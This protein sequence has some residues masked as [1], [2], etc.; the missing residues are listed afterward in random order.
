MPGAISSGTSA[1]GGGQTV[2]APA[3]TGCGVTKKKSNRRRK[4]SGALG[5]RKGSSFERKICKLLSLWWSKG[6]RDD[7]LW[8][9]AASGARHTLL[10]R[11]GKSIQQM[12]DVVAVTA[13]GESFTQLFYV[14]CKHMKQLTY[15]S[16]ML[17]RNGA[18]YRFLDSTWDRAL[19]ENREPLLIGRGNNMPIACITSKAGIETI[20]ILYD[21]GKVGKVRQHRIEIRGTFNLGQDRRAYVFLFS[22][23]V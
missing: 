3:G 2:G 13:E 8:R 7:L 9:A 18:L 5:H 21:R 16:A 15:E 6:K 19:S 17:C 12:G 23:L 14:E 11:F 22:D 10:R 4:K 1:Y 20:D